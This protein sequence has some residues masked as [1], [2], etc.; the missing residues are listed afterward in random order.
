MKRRTFLKAGAGLALAGL[1]ADQYDE[2]HGPHPVGMASCPEEVPDSAVFRVSDPSHIKLLQLTDLHFYQK[3]WKKE[4]DRQTRD[5]VRRLIDL[6]SPDLLLV[7]GDLWNNNPLHCGTYYFQQCLDW[8][9][10]LGRPWLFVWGNH[11]R[12]DDYVAAHRALAAAPG[13]LY[14]GGKHGGCYRVYLQDRSNTPIWDLICINTNGFGM[15]PVQQRWLSSFQTQNSNAFAVFHIP[16]RQQAWLWEQGQGKGVK[17]EPTGYGIEN[18]ATARLLKNHNVRACIHGH[19]HVNDYSI[20]SQGIEFIYGR[21]T[22]HAGY[23]HERVPK[24]GKLYELNAQK[25]TFA[26]RSVLADGS[27]WVPKGRFENWRADLWD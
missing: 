10:S 24:G 3:P 8:V 1:Y 15:G 13:S 20:V 9:V 22:G 7:T 11:D 23:G 4:L 5:D 27:S 17:L 14:R 18:G 12:L 2:R 25:A 26:W 21:A 6:H 16:L 19:D